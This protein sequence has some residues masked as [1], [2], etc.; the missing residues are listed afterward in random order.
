M[1]IWGIQA[2]SASTPL[3]GVTGVYHVAPTGNLSVGNERERR[4]L[5]NSFGEGFECGEG[6]CQRGLAVIPSVSVA[7][8]WW[9]H[10]CAPLLSCCCSPCSRHCSL[11]AFSL[12]LPLRFHANCLRLLYRTGSVC[13]GFRWANVD[14]PWRALSMLRCRPSCLPSD[15][16]LLVAMCARAPTALQPAPIPVHR[17]LVLGAV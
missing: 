7:I 10:Q 1:K 14:D 8:R 4:W 16:A 5:S 6:R 3:R 2:R 9:F 17:S 15:F 13:Q 12:S 11:Q